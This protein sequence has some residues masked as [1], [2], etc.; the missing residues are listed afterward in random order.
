MFREEH[1][2]ISG[3]EAQVGIFA[4]A[5]SA[6]TVEGLG[7]A[8]TQNLEQAWFMLCSYNRIPETGKSKTKGPISEEGLLPTS[9]YARRQQGKTM[10]VKGRER[11][12]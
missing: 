4:I 9:S 7:L 11:R 10:H 6:D 5:S 2:T 3:T 8:K 12:D 1:M